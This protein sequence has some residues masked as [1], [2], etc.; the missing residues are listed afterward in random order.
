MEKNKVFIFLGILLCPIAFVLWQ[1]RKIAMAK[2]AKENFEKYDSL[3]KFYSKGYPWRW[4][5]A[6]AKQESDLGQDSRVRNGKVSY[7]GLSYGL[8][9]IAVGTGSNKEKEIKAISGVNRN[10]R[11][12]EMNQEEIQIV[13]TYLN[14]V[15][16]SIRIASDL[17]EYLNRKYNGDKD[18]IFLAYN[19]GEDNTD[20]NRDFT[21]NYSNDGVSYKIKINKWL[22]WIDQN[23]KEYS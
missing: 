6:I 4:L 14:D 12:T 16:N 9:Q 7:D 18:K 3:F 13:K 1:K 23:E 22:N 15:D 20:R 11:L 10:K 19:Q 8:M 21:P 17:V 5:K 2:T